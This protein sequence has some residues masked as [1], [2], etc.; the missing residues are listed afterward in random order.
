MDKSSRKY[1][2]QHWSEENYK[3]IEKKLEA[4]FGYIPPF[5]ISETPIFID[6]AFKQQLELA[7]D[8]IL[9][10]LLD[11]EL[12]S[13]AQSVFDICP[14][15][16]PGDDSYCPFL[17]MDFGVVRT[18]DGSL[19][20]KLIELQGFPSLYYF[21]PY[22]AGLFK[23]A[24]GVDELASIFFSLAHEET[25]FKDL[26]EIIL[27]GCEP[28]E[29]VMIDIKPREQTTYIDFLCTAQYLGLKIL[30]ISEIGKDGRTLFYT[31]EIGERVNIKRIYNRIIFDELAS[32]K[33]DSQ[34][35]LTDDLDV[36]WV[37]HPNCFFTVSKY[38][39]PKL[40]GKY[41]PQS[42]FLKDA[43][44]YTLDLSK[45][46]LK[47][48]FSFAG[49]GVNLEPTIEELTQIEDVQN[50]I[51]QEKVDYAG[52]I[53]TPDDPSKCEIR[54]MFI[55]DKGAVRPRLVS[56]LVRMSKG[57]MIGVKYNKDKTWVGASVGFFV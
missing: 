51:L 46:V 34:F 26:K 1:F 20:P 14:Y 30:C 35:R 16:V 11:E 39:L 9:D 32:S 17:Q 57:K 44:L 15:K 47:P 22:L 25:Y 5:R 53:D 4:D 6:S 36:E 54:A 23:H 28:E 37:N 52:I 50:Y 24:F 42:Y 49:A 31:N 55:W 13:F 21:Q 38:I 18:S 45:Y 33:V 19:V 48:L 2:N 27:D 40:K 3:K 12:K 56:N 8:E 7:C 10:Q 41:V 43:D 29:V